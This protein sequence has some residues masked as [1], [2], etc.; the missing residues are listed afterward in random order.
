MPRAAVKLPQENP[1]YAL[2]DGSSEYFLP[3][4]MFLR[5]LTPGKAAT[6]LARAPFSQK[7]I[8]I[9]PGYRRSPEPLILTGTL[10]GE[11]GYDRLLEIEAA[12]VN[13]T[14]LRNIRDD[15]RISLAR[16]TVEAREGLYE[17]LDL[18]LYAFPSESAWRYPGEALSWSDTDWRATSW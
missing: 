14:E 12:C 4:S 17:I 8:R 3:E 5:Q 13:A 15:S 18:T 10:W 7:V 16:A 1:T 9:D 2:Y 6:T 11:D